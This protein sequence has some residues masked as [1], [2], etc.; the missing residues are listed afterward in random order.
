VHRPTHLS[1]A[2]IA[3]VVA[4]PSARA[5]A[6]GSS[7]SSTGRV[8]IHG[9]FRTAAGNTVRGLAGPHESVRTNCPASQ[10]LPERSRHDEVRGGDGCRLPVRLW[11]LR[12]VG[13]RPS[14]S[15]SD[16][17]H[18]THARSGMSVRQH[19]ERQMSALPATPVS[20]CWPSLPR[21]RA[22]D[23]VRRV[24]AGR[25]TIVADSYVNPATTVSQN[26]VKSLSSSGCGPET[27]SM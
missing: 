12:I 13:N 22:A 2:R 18:P 8:L 24:G 6:V 14:D 23:R 5:G 20:D 15:R 25:H 11:T 26:S 7:S 9:S 16:I 19:A 17:R 4:L 1:M 27:D 21:R 10:G 3:A